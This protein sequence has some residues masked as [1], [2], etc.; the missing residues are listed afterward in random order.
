[1]LWIRKFTL[2]FATAF[3][4][5]LSLS[6]AKA[7][8]IPPV[9][10][11]LV[12]RQSITNDS[13][14]VT[15]TNGEFFIGPQ[16][17]FFSGT[18]AYWL[19]SL[20][21]VDIDLTFSTMVT[22]D[23]KVVRTWAFNDVAQV[24]QGLQYFQVLSDGKQTFNDGPNGLQRLDQVVKTAAKYGIRL[25]LTLTNNWTSKPNPSIAPLTLSSDFGG[26]DVYLQAFSPG[27]THDEFYTNTEIISAFKAYIQHVISRYAD[28]PTIMAWEIANDPRCGS[29]ILPSNNCNTHTITNWV[30]EI[31]SFIKGIDK[32]HLVTAGDAGWYCLRCPK[33]FSH[34]PPTPPRAGS[35]LDGSFVVDTEDIIAV[36]GIDFGSFQLFPD[37]ADYGTFA[38]QGSFL[39][40]SITTGNGWISEHVNTS[41]SLNK[42][43]SLLAYG[44]L[45]QTNFAQFVP[46]NASNSATDFLHGSTGGVS[47]EEGNY[48]QIAWSISS[49]NGVLGGVLNYQWTQ[50]N[51]TGT[52]SGNSSLSRRDTTTSPGDGYVNGPITSLAQGARS[53]A[54]VT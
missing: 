18:N 19:Q 21:D 16:T 13:T 6:P 30:D 8:F 9:G 38:S 45:L 25:V 7:W 4:L 5:L 11:S 49:F 10:R 46:V 51:L 35:A 17:F 27:G 14:F 24:P 2:G 50:H 40:N 52:S 28:D 36:P 22:N 43:A 31:S 54:L 44:I 47:D 39:I 3:V 48:A 1:M 41:T 53:F 37:Q 23:I 33:L 20:N 32:K 34:L 26:M 15:A 29:S 42:P 12:P